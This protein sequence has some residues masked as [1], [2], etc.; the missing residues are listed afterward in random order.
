[1]DIT[2]FTSQGITP[3]RAEWVEFDSN[4][5]NAFR[6]RIKFLYHIFSDVTQQMTGY[7]Q[8][9]RYVLQNNEYVLD[10][11]YVYDSVADT[12]SYVDKNGNMVNSDDPYVW[13]VEFDYVAVLFSAPISDKDIVDYYTQTLFSRGVL[14]FPKRRE[15]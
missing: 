8:V 11:S 15:L 10:I 5:R 13:G 1:M 6:Y 4:P 7:F 9:E 2:L 12:N 3:Y 14:D